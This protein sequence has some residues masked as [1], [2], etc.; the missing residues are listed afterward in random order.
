MTERDPLAPRDTDPEV[1][2]LVPVVE[3]ALDATEDGLEY[4][5]LRGTLGEKLGRAPDPMVLMSAMESVIASGEAEWGHPERWL[6]AWNWSETPQAWVLQRVPAGARHYHVAEDVRPYAPQL[7][8]EFSDEIEQLMETLRYRMVGE[9]T[10]GHTWIVGLA[11]SDR[12]NT[13]V[14]AEQYLGKEWVETTYSEDG[15]M[16]G[17]RRVTICAVDV[18]RR[19]GPG[20]W[21]VTDRLVRTAN[22]EVSHT[23]VMRK[24]TWAP[25]PRPAIDLE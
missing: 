24:R 2:A 5:E 25:Q 11:N 23:D 16:A 14:E 7:P 3:A 17:A 22:D 18:E 8:S 19:T 20:T 12:V 1:V 13:L 4:W 10:E 6:G 9:D 21:L 15:R